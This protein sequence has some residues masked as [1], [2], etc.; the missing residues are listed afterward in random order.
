MLPKRQIFS[1]KSWL[2]LAQRTV[3]STEVPLST[4]THFWSLWDPFSLPKST[5]KTDTSIYTPFKSISSK[6]CWILLKY[7]YLTIRQPLQT[8]TK[9]LSLLELIFTFITHST[10]ISF[11]LVKFPHDFECPLLC[12]WLRSVSIFSST[13]KIIFH[14]IKKGKSLYSP[15]W[16]FNENIKIQNITENHVQQEEWF[17]S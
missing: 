7:C 6:S 13:T 12:K 2:K 4:K 3:F 5:F 9:F 8:K 16:I 15:L 10:K 14:S 11:S 17:L 1:T